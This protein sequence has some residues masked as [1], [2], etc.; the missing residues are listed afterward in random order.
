MRNASLTAHA[1]ARLTERCTLTPDRLKSLLDHG[2]SIP[3]ATQKGGR[4]AKRLVYSPA[5]QTWLIIVQ[6][7]SN[8]GVLTVMPLE[9]LKHRLPVTAAQKRSA[10]KRARSLETIRRS[11][12]HCPEPNT[13]TG[14]TPGAVAPPASPSLEPSPPPSTPPASG[15]KISARYK[16]EGR[17][18]LKTLPR[19]DA[20]HGQPAHWATPGPIHVWF[21]ERL[22]EAAIPF[23]AIQSISAQRK[24]E[25]HQAD[26]L[27]EHLP[28]TQQEIEQ[29]R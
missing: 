25:I 12:S 11:P 19:T 1:E 5:D 26:C 3:V 23:R 2:A 13:S 21:R 8:G 16:A 27:L 24:G 4:H 6:D 15:W 18:P 28:M 22:L 20:R 29:C 17:Q 14:T 10:R 9:Y 7:G